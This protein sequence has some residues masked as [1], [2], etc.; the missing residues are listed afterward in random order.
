MGAAG[1][2]GFPATSGLIKKNQIG[3]DNRFAAYYSSHYEQI[4][5]KKCG[6]AGE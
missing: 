6:R 4:G 1:L 2:T 5:P 3:L